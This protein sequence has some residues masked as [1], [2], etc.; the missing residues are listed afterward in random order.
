MAG[1]AKQRPAVSRAKM[2]RAAKALRHA[3]IPF[4]GFRL[5]PDGSVD[6]LAGEPLTIAAKSSESLTEPKDDGGWDAYDETHGG[7]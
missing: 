1:A 6:V 3:G 4:Q 7:N 2:E 5:H